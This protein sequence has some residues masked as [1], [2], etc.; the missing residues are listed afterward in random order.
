M[1][2]FV[3]IYFLCSTMNLFAKEEYVFRFS[4]NT[5]IESYQVTTKQSAFTNAAKASFTAL[6]VQPSI[7]FFVKEKFQFSFN[8][9]QSL[10]GDFSVSGLGANIQYYFLG[11]KPLKF[12]E[13]DFNINHSSLWG[14]YAGLNYRNL[15]IGS[16]DNELRFNSLGIHLGLERSL[17][18]GF[19]LMSELQLTRMTNSDYREGSS[20]G[21]KVGIG[22]NY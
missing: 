7:G 3:L 22:Y 10:S 15:L 12:T 2:K 19:L 20:L 6:Q 13:K 14:I 21:F 4:L 8:Y 5:Q 16:G 11:G 1:K 18:E 17:K 9:S